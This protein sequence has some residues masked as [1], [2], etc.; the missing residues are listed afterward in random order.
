MYK[1]E[2]LLI[3]LFYLFTNNVS[4]GQTVITAYSGANEITSEEVKNRNYT[5]LNNVVSSLDTSHNES[6]QDLIDNNLVENEIGKAILE[7]NLINNIKHKTKP[8]VKKDLS[9]TYP[10]LHHNSPTTIKLKPSTIPNGDTS[11]NDINLPSTNAKP[12]QHSKI[13]ESTTTATNGS[14]SG[15]YM[16]IIPAVDL[17]HRIGSFFHDLWA[18]ITVNVGTFF[19]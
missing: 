18:K 19:G 7:E 11:S 16:L 12:E 17:L 5:R 6:T 3:F 14:D 2:C 1:T 10:E 9:R 13:A 4:S 8:S 15:F